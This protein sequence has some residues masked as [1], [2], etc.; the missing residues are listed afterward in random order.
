MIRPMTSGI[1]ALVGGRYRLVELVGQGG[2]G[3]VWRGHDQ[4]LDREIAVKEVLVPPEL[5]GD[6]RGALAPRTTREARAAAR[7]NHPG[8]LTIRDVVEH[9]GVPWIVMEYVSGRPLAGEIAAIGRLHP[10]RVARIGAK[11]ADALAHAHAAGIIHRDLQTDN[12]LL[13]GDR[14]GLP[15]FGTAPMAGATSRLTSPGAIIGPPQYMA[16]EQLEGHDG[17]Q[18]ADMWALGATLY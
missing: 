3:R 5:I 10:R 2:M 6:E 12:I 17:G 16:P 8:I 4:V 18:P 13:P 11:I 14:G 15:A 9:G 1:E 7:L